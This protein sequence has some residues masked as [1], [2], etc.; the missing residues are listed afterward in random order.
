MSDLTYPLMVIRVTV[1]IMITIIMIIKIAT[2]DNK[3]KDI[4]NGDIHFCNG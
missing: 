1:I 3:H 4:N 2:T